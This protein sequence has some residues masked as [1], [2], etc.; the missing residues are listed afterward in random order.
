MATKWGIVSA[1][2]ISNDFTLCLR[3]L[4]QTEHQVV[5]I[6]ARSLDSAKAF[7]EKHAI[8]KAY[9]SYRELSKDPNVDIV[10]IGNLNPDHFSI[11]KMMLEAGKHVLCEKPMTM[12]LSDTEKLVALA[13]EKKLFLMEAIWS[14]FFPAYEQLRKEIQAGT[15]GDPL[16]VEATF[17]VHLQGVER[18]TKPDLGGSAVLDIGVYV[19]QMASMVFGGEKPIRVV[20][21]GYLNEHGVD[22]VALMT[23]EY[24]N[25]RMAN[26][27]I[28]VRSILNNEAVISGP[29]GFMR[30]GAPL[31]CSTV[32]ESKAKKY[33]F[34]LPIL[35]ENTNYVNGAGMT[36][37]AQEV[38]RCLQQGLLESPV[39]PL[40]ESVVI[41]YIQEEVR[42]QLGV[43]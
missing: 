18:V 17:G 35:K 22:E 15:I 36:Y 28:S 40:D 20:A 34:K 32:L 23:L 11:A 39:I 2:K 41:A 26:L 33:E 12:N 43:K 37:E 3:A 29:K 38:R 9:G 1:G 21:N 13:R 5:S 10:Y 16:L 7:A 8:P 27:T 24:S 31:W 25:S 14:R 42:K 19:I 30:I 6:A 4:P